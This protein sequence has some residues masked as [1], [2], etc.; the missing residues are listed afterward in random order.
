MLVLGHEPE[1]I[2]EPDWAEKKPSPP[3][4]LPWPGY[5]GRPRP[6]QDPRVPP[7]RL[8]PSPGWGDDRPPIEA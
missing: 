6:G 4:R 2:K 1:P 3:P 8:P 5:P 7:V